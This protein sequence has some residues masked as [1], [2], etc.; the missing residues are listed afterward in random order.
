M[1]LS[2]STLALALTAAL[3]APAAHAEIA[4]DVI[5]DS[6][7]T[8]EGL[9]QVDADWFNS[10]FANLNGD[11]LDGKDGDFG[12]RRAEL[13]LKGKGPGNVEWVLGY[14]ANANKFLDTNIKYKLGGD[15]NKFV[16]VGQFKQP[17]SLEELSSTKNN[18]FI[19]KA[20]ITNTFAVARRLGG[21]AELR[22]DQL[23]RHGQLFRARAHPQPGARQRLRPAR[24]L[25]ADQRG[26]HDPAS[27]RCRTSTWTPT[28]TPSGCARVRSR[29]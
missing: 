29:T 25:G 1:K 17:N 6:E 22:R 23:V 7:V 5:H 15:A 4:I 3:V 14:D 20:A 28:A 27:R 12:L 13:V 11:A 8:F 18:D 9:V 19:A 21:A 26:R 10:D 24:H 16:Q 2:R